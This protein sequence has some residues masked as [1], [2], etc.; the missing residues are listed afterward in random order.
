MKSKERLL[1]ALERGKPDRLPVTVHQWQQYHLDKYMGGISDLEA[2]GMLNMD[3]IVP[4]LGVV[5]VK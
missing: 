1:V 3:S 4:L 2:F 5:E